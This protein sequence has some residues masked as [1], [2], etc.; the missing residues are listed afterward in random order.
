M[1]LDR[2]LF[3][4]ELG[5]KA[6]HFGGCVIPAA[7]YFFVSREIMLLVLAFCVLGAGFLEY[8]RLNGRDLY[9]TTF[10]R[11]SEERRIGSY[12]FAALSMLLAVLLFSKKIAIAAILFLVIGDSVTGLAG[13]LL[14]MYGVKNPVDVG[15]GGGG[16]P[17][18][19]VRHHK[20]ALLMLLMFVLCGAIGLAFRPELSCLAIAAG[21]AG[22]VIADAFPWRIGRYMLDDN[23][24]IPLLAGALMTLAVLLGA[25]T[26]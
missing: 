10:M 18:Y 22:A 21:A 24:S 5:R 15:E 6:F 26:G 9:P 25:G 17:T 8:M 23:L 2:P 1:P 16:N 7:H 12:F 13:I 19:A 14:P 3:L 20:P 11:R 4:K